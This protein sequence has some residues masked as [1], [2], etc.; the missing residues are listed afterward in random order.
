MSKKIISV[1][2]SSLKNSACMLCF[3]RNVVMG[4]KHKVSSVELEFGKALHLF[5]Q[6]MCLNGGDFGK[7]MW[8]AR[9]MFEAAKY[10]VNSKKR[11]LDSNYLTN[12]CLTVWNEVKNQEFDILLGADGKP[13][14]EVTFDNVYYEDDY[15]EVH[16]RG[17]I[18]RLGKVRGGV[19]ATRDYK[20]SSSH[21]PEQ[22]FRG[23]ELSTQL[24]FYYLNMKLYAEKN[25]DSLIA[26]MCKRP[27]ASFIDGIFTNGKDKISF[28]AS[29]PFFF[30]DDEMLLY[31]KML[32]AKIQ[33]LISFVKSEIE[34]WPEGIL[35]DLCA[36]PENGTTA[37]RCSYF[38]AC[39]APDK[40]AAKHILNNDFTAKPYEPLN[41]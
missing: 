5:L 31:R 14:V 13:A 23:Y 19:F 11:Y 38:N 24:K 37:Y 21:D 16:L 28:E 40:I 3:Y 12:A 17:I 30:N 32:D 6:T 1:S 7:A 41:K 25:P 22:Y 29:R 39:A 9:E 27:V 10:S 26:E 35:T 4:Y 2:A 15:I 33:N 36:R 20:T 8:A 34:P 18:D